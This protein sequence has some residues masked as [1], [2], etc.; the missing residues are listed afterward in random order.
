[1]TLDFEHNKDLTS[2]TTFGIPTVTKLF[3]SYD[4]PAKLLK[5]S[6]S[7]EFLENPVFHIGGG[8]NLLFNEYFNGLILKSEIHGISSYQKDPD[9][10][11]VISG[12]AE[13]WTDL[14][15]WCIDKNIEGMEC[16][17]GI[18][19]EVGA[20]P[21]QN[22][23]A[24][25]IEAKDVIHNVECFDCQTRKIV[26]LKGEECGFAYRTSNFKKIWKGRYIV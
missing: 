12:A 22:V 4:T 3:I 13:K 17:A 24:Y 23:G 2:L 26:T 16:M 11:F 6:R 8:S 1:M 25:G 19:G 14:V 7:K 5:I 20:S 10:I 21:V 9:T 15:D 18:P